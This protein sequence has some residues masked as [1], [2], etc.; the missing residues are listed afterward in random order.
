MAASRV[1]GAATGG[2]APQRAGDRP[3]HGR[4]DA[5]DGTNTAAA[6]VGPILYP[7]VPIATVAA[8]QRR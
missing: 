8:P 3:R 4:A 7:A 2:G 5:A 6:E 1:T